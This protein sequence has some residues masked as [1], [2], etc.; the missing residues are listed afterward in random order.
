MFSRAKNCCNN[1]RK[2]S[3]T[4][5][6][7]RPTYV[8]HRPQAKTNIWRSRQRNAELP[9]CR[10]EARALC[11]DRSGKGIL[12]QGVVPVLCW[13]HMAQ[14]TVELSTVRMC[15]SKRVKKMLD[16]M[17]EVTPSGHFL[18][19]WKNSRQKRVPVQIAKKNFRIYAVEPNPKKPSTQ[20][21]P[22]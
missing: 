19:E 4:I 17:I 9:R 14:T 13:I 16:Q 11:N 5:I 22:S 21:H 3:E 7:V 8:F 15:A 2:Y 12:G 1:D 10:G 18:L 20:Y 6:I